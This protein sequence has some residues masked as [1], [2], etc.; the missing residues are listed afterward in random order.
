MI[1]L[2]WGCLRGPATIW[3]VCCSRL[4]RRSRQYLQ[5]CLIEDAEYLT[6]EGIQSV[7]ANA[8]KADALSARQTLLDVAS[9]GQLRNPQGQWTRQHDWCGRPQTR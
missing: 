4:P 2:L 7:D 1:L 6:A 9:L 8:S 5:Y 3:Q